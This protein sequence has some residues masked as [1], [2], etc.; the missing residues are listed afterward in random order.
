MVD[1]RRGGTGWLRVVVHQRLAFLSGGGPMVGIGALAWIVAML[2]AISVS[3]LVFTRPAGKVSTSP[4]VPGCP[5][6]VVEFSEAGPSPLDLSSTSVDFFRGTE[7]DY[8][9]VEKTSTCSAERVMFVADVAKPYPWRRRWWHWR[10]LRRVVA[11]WGDNWRTGL[12]GRR[13]QGAEGACW[14]GRAGRK[15]KV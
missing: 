11:A 6:A 13:T 8:M 12:L 4:L 9:A 3:P 5:A 2:A 7:A 15:A 10:R 14:R 1:D